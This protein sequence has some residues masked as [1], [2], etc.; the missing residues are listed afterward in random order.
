VRLE[1]LEIIVG[2][3]INGHVFNETHAH[4]LFTICSNLEQAIGDSARVFP[5]LVTM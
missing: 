5:N 1:L 3:G 2:T 4:I